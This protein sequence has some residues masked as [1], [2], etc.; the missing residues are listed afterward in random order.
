VFKKLNNFPK[1]FFFKFYLI[2]VLSSTSMSPAT[3]LANIVPPPATNANSTSLIPHSMANSANNI[4]LTALL[5]HQ[6]K[7]LLLQQ[8][9]QQ[10]Q[11]SGGFVIQQQQQKQSESSAFIVP[12]QNQ[13]FLGQ[14]GPNGQGQQ[15]KNSNQNGEISEKNA[16]R[17]PK[18]V[19]MEEIE[20]KNDGRKMPRIEE[21][22]MV[23]KESVEEE[24]NGG[25]IYEEE[26]E[27]GDEEEETI[28]MKKEEEDEAD[29]TEEGEGIFGEID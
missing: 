10:N 19:K 7:L 20:P 15:R 4:D 16:M 5:Q 12:S 14:F 11:N 27:G 23:K 28:G 3:I 25:G 8:A 2:T 24:G 1:I 17:A 9:Q 29:A 26:E 18:R 22:G 21:E 6:Q 13:Q